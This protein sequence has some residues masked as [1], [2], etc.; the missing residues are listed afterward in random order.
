[1]GKGKGNLV[2]ETITK[3]ERLGAVLGLG[4]RGPTGQEQLTVRGQVVRWSQGGD[5]LQWWWEAAGR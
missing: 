4:C 3:L 5:A 2:A 1:M